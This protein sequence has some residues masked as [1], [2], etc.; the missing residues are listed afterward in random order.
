MAERIIEVWLGA[1]GVPKPYK[2]QPGDSWVKSTLVAERNNGEVWAVRHQSTLAGWIPKKHWRELPVI[3]PRTPKS[4]GGVG[5]LTAKDMKD[6]SGGVT[7]V[8]HLMLDGKFHTADEI[9]IAAGKGGVPASEGLR[10]LRELRTW[11]DVERV[12][13]AQNKRSYQYR[14]VSRG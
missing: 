5:I 7:R 3:E 6:L 8:L 1:F 4:V 13:D 12:R 10:R 2:P 11:Y 14:L 9:R